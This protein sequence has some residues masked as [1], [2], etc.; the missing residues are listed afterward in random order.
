MAHGARADIDGLTTG[1]RG[2]ASWTESERAYWDCGGPT[3][4]FGGS[5]C[6]EPGRR[7]D[8]R[9]QPDRNI[10]HQFGTYSEDD[11]ALRRRCSVCFGN[12]RSRG[13]H[14]FFRDWASARGAAADD[15]F[16]QDRRGGTRW[17][18]QLGW[19]CGRDACCRCCGGSRKLGDAFRLRG[20]LAQRGWSRVWVVL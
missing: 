10:G 19:F 3:G 12:G 16:V 15:H 5:S 1:I 7:R 20:F 9:Q 14:S 18:D 2:H 4:T 6:G 8:G 17:R 13:R 11:G